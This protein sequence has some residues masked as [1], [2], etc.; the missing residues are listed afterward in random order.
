MNIGILGISFC[1]STLLS[2]LLGANKEIFSV[3]ESHWLVIHKERNCAVCNGCKFYTPEFKQSL[4]YS[5]LFNSIEKRV[6]EKYD[7]D[8]IVYSNKNANNYKKCINDN[9]KIDKFIL[10][11]KR[12]EGFVNSHIRHKFEK[13]KIVTVETALNLY[14][15]HYIANFKISEGTDTKIIFYDDLASQPKIILKNICD[16]IGV[17][18]SDEMLSYWNVTSKT[19]QIGGN[20]SPYLAIRTDKGF[21]DRRNHGWY[22]KVKRTI[23]L[24]DRW[25]TELSAEQI[26]EIHKNNK[27]MKLFNKLLNLRT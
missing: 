11:F 17:I 25:K 20:F 1:G 14:H 19:H 23:A 26:A 13:K 5:N 10:L 2:F 18:Y 24:D 16:W 9:T 21:L 6:K 12:P 8:K 27:V 22:K 15:E 7:I 3:G 4:T